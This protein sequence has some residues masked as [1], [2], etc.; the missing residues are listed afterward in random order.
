MSIVSIG[1]GDGVKDSSSIVVKG[2]SV[3]ADI[4]LFVGVGVGTTES[5]GSSVLFDGF[6]LGNAVGKTETPC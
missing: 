5:V 3:L 1:P 4:P 6:E 2:A